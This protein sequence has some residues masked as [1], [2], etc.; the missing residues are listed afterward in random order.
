MRFVRE[1]LLLDPSPVLFR[2][3]L[4]IGVT[5]SLSQQKLAELMLGLL[6]ALGIFTGSFQISQSF[7]LFVRN[8]EEFRSPGLRPGRHARVGSQS[9]AWAW[10]SRA[11]FRL[12]G[13]ILNCRLKCRCK[14]LTLRAQRGLDLSRIAN[15]D[16]VKLRQYTL[17]CPWTSFARFGV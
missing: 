5:S 2:P 1:C 7:R 17:N 16:T 14:R 9:V 3:L 12:N 4:P 6:R 8:P 13:P 10:D 15:V 11:D